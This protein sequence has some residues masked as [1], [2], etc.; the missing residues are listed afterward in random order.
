MTDFGPFQPYPLR[1]FCV[2]LVPHGEQSRLAAVDS[3]GLW[4]NHQ[5]Y[6]N[7]LCV[8]VLFNGGPAFHQRMELYQN[9]PHKKRG[10]RGSVALHRLAGAI[11]ECLICDFSMNLKAKSY[12]LIIFFLLLLLLLLLLI[13]TVIIFIT[14]LLIGSYIGCLA[15]LLS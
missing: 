5:V 1:D 4:G 3:A 8:Q 6:S 9:L 10:G 13:I 11:I 7:G 2:L 14:A 15:F 12:S